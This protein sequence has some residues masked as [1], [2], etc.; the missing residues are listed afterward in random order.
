MGMYFTGKILQGSLTNTI[1]KYTNTLY[2]TGTSYGVRICSRFISTATNGIL[3]TSEITADG[4]NYTNLCQLMSKMSDNLDLMFSIA[5][6]S[7]DTIDQYNQYKDTLS[8][9]KNNRTNVPYVQTINGVDYW[10][11][12]GKLVST[13]K[14]ESEVITDSVTYDMA[15]KRIEN[16]LD[17]KS[18]NDYDSIPDAEGRVE[19]T[20]AE[21]QK[22]INDKLKELGETFEYEWK[23]LPNDCEHPINK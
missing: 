18:Y 4:T 13:V 12:N 9:I 16:I 22:T 6:Q 2:G 20:G 11:V 21:I 1:T 19:A 17:D 5:N 15:R 8:V 23:Y 14:A 3:S 7:K 10:F